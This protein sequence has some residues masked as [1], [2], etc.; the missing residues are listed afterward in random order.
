M[1][2]FVNLE[3]P[4]RWRIQKF[5]DVGNFQY[6]YTTSSTRKNSGVRLL[7]ITDIGENGSVNW[8]MVP[9]GEIDDRDFENYK[10]KIGDILFAR[11]G[12]TTGKT[13]IINKQAPK[14]IFASYL[15]RFIAKDHVNPGYFFYYTYSSFYYKQ[16]NAGKEGKLKKGLNV[17]QLKDFIIPLPPLAE[18]KKISAVL[19]AVQ[20]AK[21][22]T[23][24][25]IRAGQE[26]KKSLMNHLFTYGPVPPQDVLHVKLKD[27]EIGFIPISW[28][29]KPLVEIA[30]L[31]RGRDLPRSK[32]NIGNYPVVGSGGILGYHN[33]Y[34]CEPPGLVTGRSGSIGSIIYI[35]E[36]YWPHNTGLYVKDFH[37]NYQKFV[38]YLLHKFEFKKYST[39]VSV[40]TLNRNFV[41]SILLSLPPLEI[42]KKISE[43][44]TII[45]KKIEA[46]ETKKTA[47]DNLFKTLL[48]NL[49]TGKTRVNHLELP[50]EPAETTEEP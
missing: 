33:E 39:G 38:Y 10:L 32:M 8:N 19:S 9:F 47:L 28:E 26:L 18:Q 30:T 48:E 15:I 11:I 24:E 42:Q 6:G 40:P 7:R 1:N 4:D 13:C 45:D 2:I 36:K 46:E 44:L 25:V 14:S 43:I 21:E 50:V 49:M 31:Q 3:L 22:K 37:G 5:I 23:G 12:A 29:V 41:H 35:E 20:E 16:V 17:N 34:I 27:S